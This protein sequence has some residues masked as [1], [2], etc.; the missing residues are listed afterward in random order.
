[1]NDQPHSDVSKGT[2]VIVTSKR[3]SWVVVTLYEQFLIVSNMRK[4]YSR[5]G[6]LKWKGT[7]PDVK[8]SP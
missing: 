3:K 7:V 6:N 2:L 4:R 1:M 8:V 5:S